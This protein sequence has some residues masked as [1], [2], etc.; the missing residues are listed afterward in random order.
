[1][2]THVNKVNSVMSMGS[3]LGILYFLNLLNRYNFNYYNLR[4]CIKEL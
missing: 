4:V 2:S 1:M 3:P